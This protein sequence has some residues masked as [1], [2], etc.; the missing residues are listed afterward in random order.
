MVS[1][2]VELFGITIEFEPLTVVPTSPQYTNRWRRGK[3]ILLVKDLIFGENVVGIISG[4]TVLSSS[5]ITL[6]FIVLRNYII[7][8]KLEQMFHVDLQRQC[9]TT[10]RHY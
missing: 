8:V 4:L 7:L 2:E 1:R 10:H 6:V 9:I 3:I 5:K